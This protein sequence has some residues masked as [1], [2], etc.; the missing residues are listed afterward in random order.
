[1]KTLAETGAI[2]AEDARLLRQVKEIVHESLPDATV[3]LYGSVARGTQ[4]ADS[5][6][7][8]LVLTGQALS[9]REEDD[10]RDELYELQLARGVLV[11]TMFYARSEWDRQSAFPLNREVDRDGVVL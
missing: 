11:T 5:D 1:M 8:I 7:D 9:C 2:S 3:L 6:Y 4:R 10:V